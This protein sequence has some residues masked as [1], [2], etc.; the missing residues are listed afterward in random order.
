VDL[1]VPADAKA[2]LESLLKQYQHDVESRQKW[3]EFFKKCQVSP[4]DIK[5]SDEELQTLFK[6]KEAKKRLEE[7]LPKIKELP[8]DQ[9][10]KEEIMGKLDDW[11]KK[12]E[13]SDK[14]DNVPPV[15]N[16][17]SDPTKQPQSPSQPQDKANPFD[18]PQFGQP[19][20]TDQTL[21]AK[22]LNSSDKWSDKFLQSG[23]D[24]NLAKM[25]WN[26][27]KF[28]T[29]IVK[30]YH[31][32][33]SDQ[34]ALGTQFGDMSKWLDRIPQLDWNGP[35]PATSG[36]KMGSFDLPGLPRPSFRM[37]ATGPVGNPDLATTSSS[38]WVAVM[39][40]VL[41]VVGVMVAFGF[42]LRGVRSSTARRQQWHPG[43]WPVDPAR[44]LTPEELVRAFDHLA[45]LL[46]GRQAEHFNHRTIA[47]QLSSQCAGGKHSQPAVETLA[48][49]YEQARYAPSG[50]LPGA[51]D[52][53]R[54]RVDLCALAGVGRT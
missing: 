53:Q 7:F 35:L 25:F 17:S 4:K 38:T 5:F 45:L 26:S 33:Q 13:Q 10:Q 11:M 1:P 44:I 14:V 29:S 23:S 27:P 51:N 28:R 32:K 2:R 15:D 47:A 16:K 41:V 19:P 6:G 30:W 21:A 3:A 36:F 40:A 48:R 18:P 46:L 37:P 12:H 52:L 42:L 39:L 8:L 34:N 43:P 49:T 24:S 54:A 22:K 31:H 9:R 50:G 20:I